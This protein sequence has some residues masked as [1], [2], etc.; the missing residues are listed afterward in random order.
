MV[1][2]LVIGFLVGTGA[3]YFLSLLLAFDGG[4]HD[5]PGEVVSLLVVSGIGLAVTA[6][7][8]W[9][10]M[11]FGLSALWAKVIAT[12]LALAWNYAGRRLFVFTPNMPLRTWRLSTRLLAASRLA[13]SRSSAP[14]PA[15]SLRDE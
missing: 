10:F 15:G 6:V 5:G 14:P 13:L 1:I 9:S 4:R 3:N 2:C 11:T 7:L 12:P 8:V